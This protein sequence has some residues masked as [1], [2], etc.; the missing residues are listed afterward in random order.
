MNDWVSFLGKGDEH[1]I[2]QNVYQQLPSNVVN[3]HIKKTED[4]IC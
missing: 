2:T 4:I 3:D 1:V